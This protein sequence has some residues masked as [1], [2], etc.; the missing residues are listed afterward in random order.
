[1]FAFIDS[2]RDISQ[3]DVVSH[4]RTRQE[5]ALLF[6]QSTLSQ[7]IKDWKKLKARIESNPMALSSKHPRVVA[8]PDVEEALVHWVKHM[9]EKGET[10]NGPML[11]VKRERFEKQMDVLE[12]ERLTGDGWVANFCSAYK[13]KEY[14]RHGEA[15]SV[16][17]AGVATECIRVQKKFANVAPCD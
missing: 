3:A 13:I 14:R 12:N 4:F 15:G 10:V 9:E 16:D 8:Q 11:R 1:M 5:G 2:H 7:K 6:T 17:L